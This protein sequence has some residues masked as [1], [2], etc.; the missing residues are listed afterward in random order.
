MLKPTVIDQ[1][2]YEQEH[3]LYINRLGECFFMSELFADL[4]MPFYA[5]TCFDERGDRWI[6]AAFQEKKDLFD[7]VAQPH[8]QKIERIKGA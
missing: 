3:P 7:W 5:L 8:L 1:V 4:K 6:A 2:S